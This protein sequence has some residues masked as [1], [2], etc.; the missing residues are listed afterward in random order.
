[1]SLV[2]EI[3]SAMTV[4]EK[5]LYQT[6]NRSGQDPLNF[7]I[8]LNNKLAHLGALESVGDHK[9]TQQSLDYRD[10]VVEAIDKELEDWYAIKKNE[11]PKVNKKI[12]EMSLD[13]I[14]LE[15]SKSL[16]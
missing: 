4:V 13:Y 5:D 6:K 16:I 8:K 14:Q 11:I 7:P 3:D 2:K 9:P 10:E 15:P 12:K 1:M